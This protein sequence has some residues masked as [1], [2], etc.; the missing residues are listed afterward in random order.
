M[1]V[2]WGRARLGYVALRE[3]NVAE[4]HQILVETIEDFHRDGN[5]NGLAFALDRMA[6]LHAVIN[7]PEVAARLIGWSDATRENIG[8]RRPRLEQT[9]LDRDIDSSRAKLGSLAFDVAYDSGRK[10]ALD[11]AVALAMGAKNLGYD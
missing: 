11:E 4:A 9:D 3:G 1:G 5:K 8:D 6:S 2:L 7:N 10:M